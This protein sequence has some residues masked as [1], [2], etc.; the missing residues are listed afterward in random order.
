[1][2][3]GARTPQVDIDAAVAAGFFFLTMKD[4]NQRPKFSGDRAEFESWAFPFE[5]DVRELGWGMLLEGAINHPDVLPDAMLG[6][7]ARAVGRNLF[8]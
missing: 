4:I 6:V 1:M 3:G 2:A 8:L 5:C 7:I